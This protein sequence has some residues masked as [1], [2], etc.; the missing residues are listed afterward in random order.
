[1]K[2]LHIP[3]L[4]VVEKHTVNPDVK[5]EY[6]NLQS[7]NQGSIP[8]LVLGANPYIYRH[9]QKS[10]VQS[11]PDSAETTLRVRVSAISSPL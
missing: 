11:H 2:A 5:G 9:N 1:M 7:F 4:P 3:V 10:C 6:L 8:R